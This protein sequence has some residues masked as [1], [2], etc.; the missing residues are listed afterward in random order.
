MIVEAARSTKLLARDVNSDIKTLKRGILAKNGKL[1]SCELGVLTNLASVVSAD[2]LDF[3]TGQN[4]DSVSYEVLLDDGIDGIA[5]KYKVDAVTVHSEYNPTTKAN[6]IA[7]LEYNKGQSITWN[8]TIAIKREFYW[9]NMVYSRSSV[10]DLN[11]VAWGSNNILDNPPADDSSCNTMSTLYS[12]NTYDFT[13][14]ADTVA[15]PDSYL[16]PCNIPYGTVYTYIGN[17]L[18]LAGFYSYSS[19]TG[20]SNDDS[21]GGPLCGTGTVRNYYL[22]IADWTLFIATRLDTKMLYY[23]PHD[24][25]NFP[26]LNV[27]YAL[28][29]PTTS[30]KAGVSLA[31]GDYF[32]D[33]GSF[34]SSTSVEP[35]SLSSFSS[36]TDISS[37]DSLLESTAADDQTHEAIGS[38]SSTETEGLTTDTEYLSNSASKDNLL[39]E[40]ETNN[41]NN[42]NTGSGA[43]SSSSTHRTIIIAVVVSFVGGISMVAG[44]FY[45]FR[46][47]NRS[48]KITIEDPVDRAAAENLNALATDSSSYIDSSSQRGE[49]DE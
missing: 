1:T 17:T 41:N 13:C 43:N 20:Q 7:I 49:K 47:W 14:M 8:N 40:K 16:S 44:L 6:N 45:M 2:C 24:D 22:M 38:A 21:N 32:K 27:N 5:A 46:Q 11:S 33:Q 3:S 34:V 28:T 42:N 15:S 9:G 48:R 29:P 25:N 31:G 36:E 39:D 4:L 12:G 37:N 30:D 23:Y 35:S 26:D 10:S 18:Y 19:V